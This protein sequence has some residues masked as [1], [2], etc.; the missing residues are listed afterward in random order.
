MGELGGSGR[1]DMENDSGK[2]YQSSNYVNERVANGG[3]H[4]C[5]GSTG[6]DE[7]ECACG[8][9]LPENEQGDEVAGQNHPRR[10]ACVEESGE[11]FEVVV[12]LEIVDRGDECD[13][14]EDVDEDKAQLIG[15][16]EDQFEVE[17]IHG[18]IDPEVHLQVAVESN[19]GQG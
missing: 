12:A 10:T 18:P 15:P 7:Q 9:H 6:K 5:F 14:E 19:Y 17:D 11:V 3:A 16:A 4:G 2:E 1:L 13:H 8:E